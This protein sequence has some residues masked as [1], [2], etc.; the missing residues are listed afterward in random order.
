MVDLEKLEREIERILRAEKEGAL[1]EVPPFSLLP[2]AERGVRD[3]AFSGDG[4]PTL[5]PHFTEAV[6][7][8]ARARRHFGLI[9]AKLV[10]LTNAAYLDRP[11][12]KAA[13]AVLDQNNGEIWAKL[14]AGTEKYFRRVNRANVSLTRIFNNILEAAITRPLVIQS[15]WLRIKGIT[16]SAGEIEAYC[17]RLNSL[18]SAHGQLKVIQLYTI[19]RDPAEAYVSALSNEELDRIGSIVKDRLSV[20]VGK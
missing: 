19:A 16:P 14:D 8:V 13:L 11:E 18:I 3:I 1:Y 7:I 17:N 10:L 6:R 20:P 5:Y 15:L 12:I 9:S 4:E 2:K